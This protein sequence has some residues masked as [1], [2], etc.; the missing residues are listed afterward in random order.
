M[1]PPRKV[2]EDEPL[3]ETVRQ[4]TSRRDTLRREI[5]RPLSRRTLLRGVAGGAAV[6]VALPMLEAFFGRGQRAYADCGAFPARFGWWF[7]GNG[8]LPER[9]T[10]RTTGMAWE[11]SDQLMPLLPL[12]DKITVVSGTSV[13]TTNTVPHGS[14][15]SGFLS[16]GDMIGSGGEASTGTHPGPTLDQIVAEAIGSQT[17][18]RSLELGVQRSTRGRSF[19]GPGAENPPETDPAVLYERLF[20]A[21]FRLPGDMSAPDPRLAL[22]RRVL[23]GVRE[24]A[25]RLRGRLGARDRERLDAHLEGIARIETQ[26][27]RLQSDPP[28]L[29]ACRRPDAPLADYPDIEGRPQVQAVSRVMSDMMALALA[30]DQTRAFSVVFSQPVNNVLFPRSPAGHHQLT[31]DEPG[32]QPEVHAIVVQIIEE[33]AYFFGALDAIDEVD[34]TVLDHSLVLGTTDVSYGRTHSLQEYP[35]VLAGGACGAIRTGLHVRAEGENTCKV[36]LSILR[37]MGLAVESF[38]IGVG[39]TTDGLSAIEGS[40]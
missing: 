8:V 17:R 15:P 11:P 39:R 40:L 14:G 7:F 9:W 30:C 2:H 31:H 13:L 22:R 16:G 37:A 24:Q 21:G 36:S 27:E 38:G 25:G 18:F 4:E 10:P 20:G 12:R 35:I 5:V 34:G 6:S 19:S 26:I 33:M 23:D 3:H 28:R 32:G 29:E 1:R